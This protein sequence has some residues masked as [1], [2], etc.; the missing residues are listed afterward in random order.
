MGARA[1]HAPVVPTTHPE[2]ET[3]IVL[4]CWSSNDSDNDLR[5]F[6]YARPHIFHVARRTERDSIV[7]FSTVSRSRALA[8]QLAA[9]LRRRG[10]RQRS[11]S[12]YI[13]LSTFMSRFCPKYSHNEPVIA[14]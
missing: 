3:V 6:E 14:S 11:P 5:C 13:Q 1:Q 10:A 9:R 12:R 2:N 8:E 4:V 7:Y